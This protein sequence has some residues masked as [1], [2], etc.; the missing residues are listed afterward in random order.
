LDC[1]QFAYFLPATLVLPNR[2]NFPTAKIRHIRHSKTQ[3]RLVAEGAGHE[4]TVRNG[5][6]GET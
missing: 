2:D 6:K 5:A 1:T 3:F 4:Y